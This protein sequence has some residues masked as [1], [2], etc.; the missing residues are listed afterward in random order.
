M[1]DQGGTPQPDNSRPGYRRV[2]SDAMLA[3]SEEDAAAE[4]FAIRSHTKRQIT[5]ITLPLAAVFMVV[6][7]FLWSRIEA[8]RDADVEHDKQILQLQNQDITHDRA[9]E[10]D[11]QFHSTLLERQKEMLKRLESQERDTYQL[12]W[13]VGELEKDTP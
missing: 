6:G 5:T 11:L 4:Q 3:W 13:R 12:N 2:H 1:S 9:L 7:G 10:Q 8:S